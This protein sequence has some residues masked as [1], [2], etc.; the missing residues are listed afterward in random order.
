MELLGQAGWRAADGV[1]QT[2]WAGTP[3]GENWLLLDGWPS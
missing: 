1:D 2:R 3:R